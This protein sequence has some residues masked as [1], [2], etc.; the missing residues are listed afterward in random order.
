MYLLYNYELAGKEFLKKKKIPEI[1]LAVG[2]GGFFFA[3]SD[4][5]HEIL[6]SK[7]DHFT[8]ILLYF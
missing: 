8:P 5:N 7:T 2:A 1:W 4:H 6:N 3:I